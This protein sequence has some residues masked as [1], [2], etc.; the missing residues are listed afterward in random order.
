MPNI[1]F[2]SN[3]EDPNTYFTRKEDY[4]WKAIKHAMWEELSKPEWRGVTFFIPIS[5]SFDR[6]VLYCAERLHNDVV[7]YIP[8]QEWGEYAIPQN[9]IDLVKRMKA[10]YQKKVIRGNQQRLETMLED[11]DAAFALI[12]GDSLDCDT[13]M[14]SNKKVKLFDFQQAVNSYQH[15]LE[16]K[17]QPIH[18]R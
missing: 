15:H 7:L 18:T 14:L 3:R 4:N 10:R 9:Q 11:C 17:Q 2:I 6:F 5:S 13:S 16:M 8:Q 1:A 12:T